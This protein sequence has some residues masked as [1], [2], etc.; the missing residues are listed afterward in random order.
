MGQRQNYDGRARAIRRSLRVRLLTGAL[1]ALTATAC[2]DDDDASGEDG[3]SG[4]NGKNGGSDAFGNPNPDASTPNRMSRD[5]GGFLPDVGG[6]GHLQVR[7][8]DLLFMVDN[9]GSMKEEQEA[10]RREF[11]KMIQVLTSG[12]RNGDGQEDF[13]PIAE[14]HLGVVSS[15]LGLVGITA[16]AK[17]E[18]LGDDGVLQNMPPADATDCKAEY[19]RFLTFE[20]GVHDPEEVAGDFACIAS[21]G[22]A[23]CGFEQQ[24]E[25]TLKAVWPSSD[26]RITFIGDAQGLG[27]KGHGDTENAGFL[28]PSSGADTSLLAV[29]LVTDE[30]DCSSSDLSHFL[31]QNLLPD[32][33]PLKEQ[34]LN[35][36][37]HLNQQNLFPI[38]RYVDG[39]RRLRPG[40]ENLVVFGAIT[41]V[42]TGMVDASALGAVDFEDSASVNAFYDG[43]LAS[44]EMTETVDDKGTPATGDDLLMPS[45]TNG[46]SGKAYPPRRIVEVA[47]QF[48]KNSIVQSICQ[49]DFGPAVDAIVLSITRAVKDACIVM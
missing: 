41:G 19:P 34:G 14:L 49:D 44:A 12:D 24:L 4:S 32:G 42:P 39:F 3:A 25:T 13:P 46:D 33:S 11:P 22:T 16:I 29:V 36:R 23:G 45:C 21:L 17:C 6:C 2:G 27:T 8:L 15:D 38:Q 18:G 47:K 5:S 40:S 35:V 20:A 9:S 7:N 37:C 1:V 31:P 10:L 30:D 26:D 43:I 28:R 48:G